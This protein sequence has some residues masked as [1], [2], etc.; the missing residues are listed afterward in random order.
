MLTFLVPRRRGSGNALFMMVYVMI[1][2]V[3]I[4]GGK[5]DVGGCWMT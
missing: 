5:T 1:M 3:A 4:T 2:V